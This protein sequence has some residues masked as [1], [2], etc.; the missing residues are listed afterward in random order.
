MIL[1]FVNGS[2]ARLGGQMD[3]LQVESKKLCVLY[4]DWVRSHVLSPILEVLVPHRVIHPTLG[5]NLKL[6]RLDLQYGP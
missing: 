4:K 1:V 3:V 6:H 2:V 5:R